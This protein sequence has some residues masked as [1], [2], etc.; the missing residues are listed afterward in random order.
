MPGL[1]GKD[2]TM[3]IARG[4]DFFSTSTKLGGMRGPS[5]YDTGYSTSRLG[6]VSIDPSIRAIQEQMLA[7][8]N[9]LYNQLGQSAESLLGNQNAYIQARVNPLEQQL[10]EREGELGRS[11]G[12]RGLS[13][14]SFGEQ[15]MTN[16]NIDK[17]RA[18]GDAR[19][20]A[21]NDSL[22]QLA[23]IRAQQ[24]ASLGLDSKTAQD[25]M[26][27][28]LQALGL[29]KSQI[30]QAMQA[31]ISYQ[32]N[33]TQSRSGIAS[34]V[35]G[36]VKSGSGSTPSAGNCFVAEVIYGV[37][38]PITL[39][40]RSFVK[41]HSA[42]KTLLGKFFRLYIKKGRKWA[43]TVRDNKTI[44]M[45]AKLIW[46]ELYKMAMKENGKTV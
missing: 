37:D 25:R 43:E 39:T 12:L 10:T 35:V 40:I 27:N 33:S 17:N 42:D 20:T 11:I 24:F 16:F 23:Q 46:D 32:Q 1:A 22:G 2:A 38:S 30:D 18:L 21:L 31:Y 26:A 36:G 9:N 41:K 28:E 34:S 45:V 44:R 19:S 3:G 7:R 15:A 29:G 14:S 6:K 13:G 8:N 4:G 5:T